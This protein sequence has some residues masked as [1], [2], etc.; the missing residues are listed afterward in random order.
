M[1]TW[2][3]WQRKVVS[4]VPARDRRR[5]IDDLGAGCPEGTRIE[6]LALYLPRKTLE[7]I[8]EEMVT[9]LA[10]CRPH[11]QLQPKLG[12]VVLRRLDHGPHLVLVSGEGRGAC[13]RRSRGGQ[14]RERR[15]PAC[16]PGEATPCAPCRTGAGAPCNSRRPPG[17]R[18]RQA[19]RRSAPAT[20]RRHARRACGERRIPG[21]RGDGRG[22]RRTRRGGHLLSKRY[23]RIV[24]VQHQSEGEALAGG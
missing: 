20:C 6:L 16:H 1:S 19:P 2:R 15:S 10:P 23:G 9:L 4:S 8:G 21:K 7:D 18:C 12:S 14:G 24:V 22:R 11:F 17:R 3:G 5:G 13:R